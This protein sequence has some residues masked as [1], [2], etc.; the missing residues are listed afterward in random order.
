MNIIESLLDRI[1]IGTPQ[2]IGDVEVLPL[3]AK[4]WS[5]QPLLD[6]EEAIECGLAEV[7]ELTE[8]GSVPELKVLNKGTEDIIAFDGEQLIGAKQNR[9]LNLTVIIP[10]NSVVTIPVSCV[11]QG[12][13]HYNSQTFASGATFAYPSLRAAKHVG[14]TRSMRQRGRADSDQSEV[15]HNIL[16][17]AARMSVQ[18]ETM[19]MADIYEQGIKKERLM[20]TDSLEPVQGQIG[21]LAYVR[22]GFAGGDLF[23][24]PELCGRKLR[25]ILKGY[26]LDSLDE[27]ISFIRVEPGAV[28]S[29]IKDARQ[30]RFDSV[31]KGKEVRFD[32]RLVQGAWK[33]VDGFI[34]HL[35][36]LP[37]GCE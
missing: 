7:Q 29:Q 16:T 8:S 28:M 33:E 21:Y 22:G 13:W 10:A 14:V 36:V 25:K 12:R 17:K 23:C 24:S 27:E 31:G 6:L 18:S 26:L 37:K 1:A 2:S 32:G 5:P 11:E 30:E 19:A 20:G 4:E 9:I 3:I 15:W 35:H 34:P